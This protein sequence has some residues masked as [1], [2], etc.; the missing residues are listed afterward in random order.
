MAPKKDTYVTEHFFLNVVVNDD[1]YS[2][3]CVHSSKMVVRSH[4]S[5]RSEG[6]SRTSGLSFS[7]FADA[8][9]HRFIQ[10]VAGTSCFGMR[11]AK[12]LK[13]ERQ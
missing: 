9:I 10:S 6:S 8:H 5:P 12:Y 1:F 13:K 7:L 3:M 2:N 4:H 11:R